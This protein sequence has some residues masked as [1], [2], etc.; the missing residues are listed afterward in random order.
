MNV[1]SLFNG[2][3]G[4]RLA[5]DRAKIPIDKFYSSEID[6][7]AIQVADKNYPED[8]PY[9]LG[10]VKLIDVSI[11]DNI[12]IL[13][14]GSPCQSFSFAGKR[15]GMTTKENIDI[16]TLDHYLALKEAHFEFTGQ[17]YLFW[18]YARILKDLQN[19]NPDV[20]FLL[21][22]T[23]MAPKWENTITQVLGV[24]TVVINSSLVSAQNRKRL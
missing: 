22:N 5:F 19:I 9:K 17:S 1:M 18:E 2:L 12:D 14:G 24:P 3:S 8:I 6:P 15:E 16:L 10:D 23:P 4:A 20:K 21:E 7:Y 11:L 13:I